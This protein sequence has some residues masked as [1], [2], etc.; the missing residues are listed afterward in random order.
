MSKPVKKNKATPKT[1]KV[2]K[3]PI[4]KPVMAQ[5][6]DIDKEKTA[7]SSKAPVMKESLIREH[8]PLVKAITA[9]IFS[10]GKIPPGMTFDDMVSYGIEGLTKAHENFDKGRGVEFKV[11]ASYRIRGEILDRIRKEWR[12]RS[13]GSY[14]TYQNL[15][16]S[17]ISEVAKN[18]L[19]EQGKKISEEEQAKKL[20][21]MMANT[22]MAY[23]L[24]TDDVQ[25]EST[26]EGSQDPSVEVIDSIEF[27]RE[28]KVL[29]E[30]IGTL[31]EDERKL[32][33]L[34]YVEN[35]SQKEIAEEL[36]YSKSKISRI[37]SSVLYKLRLRLNRKLS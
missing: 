13:P 34:F 14:K 5:R 31:P 10:A 26:M 1:T 30:E 28:R 19:N 12:Y 17:K 8:L 11:Y 21:N 4:K 16:A 7:R 2:S 22:A 36:G 24:S 20:M 6:V 15:I 9:N 29:W 35:K 3:P 37:H 25:V 23:L 33:N 18:S 27:D 32:V